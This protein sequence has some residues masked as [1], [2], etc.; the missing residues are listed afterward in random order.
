MGFVLQ[1]FWTSRHVGS[2]QTPCFKSTEVFLR[3]AEAQ[4]LWLEDAAKV[5]GT[6]DTVRRVLRDAGFYDEDIQ[7]GL[8]AHSSCTASRE[9][10]S[11][12]DPRLGPSKSE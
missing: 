3:A 4:G 9:V 8:F 1:S 12:L 10:A 5:V 6:L 11:R 2:V 7:A